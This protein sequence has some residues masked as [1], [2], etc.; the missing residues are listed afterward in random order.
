MGK[1]LGVGVALLAVSMALFPATT[2][3]PLALVYAALLGMSGGVIT[4]IY[5]AV[6][7]H[8]YGRG[9]LGAIQ[10]TVQVLSVLASATGPVV[11][12]AC[13]EFAGTTD[14]F[15]Y[16]FAGGAMILAVLAWVVRPPVPSSER[17]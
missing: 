10:A 3:V 2:T 6:Y 9:H 1:L 17:G 8:T 7:G 12:A 11:L 5:F 16:F 15:F 4:V 13:R 14:P